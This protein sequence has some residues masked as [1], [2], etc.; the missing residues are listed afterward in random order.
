MF[1]QETLVLFIFHLNAAL[2]RDTLLLLIVDQES[3]L[4]I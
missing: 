3:K 2:S 4:V 1:E